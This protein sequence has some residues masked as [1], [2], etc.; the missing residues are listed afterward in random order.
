MLTY[1]L[2][3]KDDKRCV[4]P[5]V[6]VEVELN[7]T[8]ILLVFIFENNV[9]GSVPIFT[10]VKRLCTFQNLY[11]Q[12]YSQVILGPPLLSSLTKRI[13]ILK[14]GSSCPPEPCGLNATAEAGLFTMLFPEEALKE[15]R[16]CLCTSLSTEEDI[17][18]F[19]KQQRIKSKVTDNSPATNTQKC[20]TGL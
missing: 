1:S 13:L 14:S 18:L 10:Y 5:K 20:Q 8:K 11:C 16:C 15:K 12:S 3:V 7:P 19:R 17:F 6:I 4:P 2:T 9:T